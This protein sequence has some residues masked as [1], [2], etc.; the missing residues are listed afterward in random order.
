MEAWDK[1]LAIKTSIGV[2]KWLRIIRLLLPS[3]I[4][5]DYY[6]TKPQYNWTC[7]IYPEIYAYMSYNISM[8]VCTIVCPCIA[9][10]FTHIGL[11]YIIG[12][13]I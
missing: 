10:P 11:L 7:G 2:K 5:L 9:L 13:T 3:E 1:V 8:Y 12:F 4:W 6:P